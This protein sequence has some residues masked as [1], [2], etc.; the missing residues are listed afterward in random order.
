MK[1][2]L[3]KTKAKAKYLPRRFVTGGKDKSGKK[4]NAEQFNVYLINKEHNLA[5][6]IQ[7]YEDM[8]EFFKKIEGQVLEI[9]EIIQDKFQEALS[10]LNSNKSPGY[11][12]ISSQT[13]L[14]Q[15]PRKYFQL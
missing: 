15:F 7:S 11:H 8:Y 6:N 13:L 2:I 4:T 12:D 5:A 14:K 9:K 3:E 1:K 10:S